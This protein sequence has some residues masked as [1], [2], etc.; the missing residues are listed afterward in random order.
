MF[1]ANYSC[2][3]ARIIASFAEQGIV[4]DCTSL[5]HDAIFQTQGMVSG[6]Y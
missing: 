3:A 1:V 6:G 4:L 5:L 2:I